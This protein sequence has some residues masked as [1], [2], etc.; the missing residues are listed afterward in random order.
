MVIDMTVDA[1][2]DEDVRIVGDSPEETVDVSRYSITSYGADF[3]VEGWVRR[4]ERGDIEIPEFQR[5]YVWT[6]A[7]ASRFVESLLMGLPVPAIFL[8]RDRGSSTLQV[9]D[10]QQ[11]LM[12]LKFYF[13]GKFAE[14]GREFRLTGLK[15]EFDGCM[16]RDLYPSDRRKLND[17]IIHASIIQQEAPDVEGSSK[18]ALFDRLNTT[19][20][21]LSPQEI[22][23]AIFG[24]EL[25]KLLVELNQC[26]RWRQLFGPVHRR[27]RDEELILRFLA[28]YHDF[29][30]YR[31]PMKG[32]LNDH[33]RD[34]RNLDSLSQE[35]TRRLFE[36]TVR[37]IH[38]KLGE[39]AFKRDR[40]VNAALMDALMVG[41]AR[42]LKAGPINA[43]LR[44]QYGSLLED[45]NF[46][47]AIS[48]G[49]AQAENVRTRIKLATEAFASVE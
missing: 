6:K 33:M 43:D 1:E 34:R 5:A 30:N 37:V 45:E 15:S 26:K 9:I 40:A 32:F 49:T 35:E 13:E 17:A 41:V 39:R 14:T 46:E 16:Y 24:G 22:R 42:R 10:G 2:A 28:L 11:R 29:D 44:M 47:T 19:S 4:M 25:S 38:E 20:T 48:S 8:Y 21:Q 7:R 3:D 36:S 27:R 12:T 31:P 18:F 23:A